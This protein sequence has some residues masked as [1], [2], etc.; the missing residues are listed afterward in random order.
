MAY[1]SVFWRYAVAHGKNRQGPGAPDVNR[2]AYHAA[3]QA[4]Q[5]AGFPDKL[6]NTLGGVS[7]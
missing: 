3:G 7:V 2:P 5:P 6:S 4:A 1:G